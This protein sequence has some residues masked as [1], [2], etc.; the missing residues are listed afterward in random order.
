MLA[1]IRLNVGMALLGAFIGEFT[2]SRYGL[3]HLIIVAEGLYDV[4]QI[5]VGVICIKGLAIVLHSC[6]LPIERWASRWK[7]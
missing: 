5:W 3:G 1:G 6:T 4:N 7:P 2:S